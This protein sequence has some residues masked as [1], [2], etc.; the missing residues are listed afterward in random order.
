MIVMDK[1]EEFKNA[2]GRAK[3]IVVM[4][5]AGISCPPPTNIKDFRSA[6]G[7][8]SKGN[9][10]NIPTEE[11]LSY[12]FFKNHPQE[13]FKFYRENLVYPNALYNDA[14]KFFANLE[15]SKEV[16]IITQNIDGLHTKAGSSNVLEIHGSVF[17]NHCISCG[18]HYDLKNISLE[19]VPTCECGGI[20]KPNVVLYGEGLDDELLMDAREYLA[21]ADLLIV[22]GTSL[23][24]YPAARLVKNFKGKDF[25]I[26]NKSNT[27][28]DD[29]ATLV[30]HEDILDVIHNVE[31]KMSVGSRK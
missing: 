14:H 8:Y 26:I 9:E 11:I 19:D 15:K 31:K 23:T 1:Y 3:K 13:F 6:D 5:G 7:L 10:F 17:K 22:V 24:V 18:K 16:V 30:F 4:T 29:M 12:R 21:Y 20:I 25:I 2:I 28:Y 27:Q